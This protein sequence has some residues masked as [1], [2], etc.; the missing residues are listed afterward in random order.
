[1]GCRHSNLL[2]E[3]HRCKNANGYKRDDLSRDQEMHERA[4]AA[5]S[6]YESYIERL[7]EDQENI[8]VSEC[9]YRPD[10]LR[11]ALEST[12]SSVECP[13]CFEKYSSNHVPC[14]LPCGHSF[15][16]EHA[17]HVRKCPICREPCPPINE[18]SKSVALI[19]ASNALSKVIS[20]V[21]ESEVS[22][23]KVLSENKRIENCVNCFDEL[24]TT[25]ETMDQKYPQHSEK[26]VSLLKLSRERNK[27]LL[28]RKIISP[29]NSDVPDTA[30]VTT[31]EESNEPEKKY[32]LSPQHSINRRVMDFCTE[33]HTEGNN[34]IEYDDI[35]LDKFF[36]TLSFTRNLGE[37][38]FDLD[39]ISMKSTDGMSERVEI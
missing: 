11:K 38:I 27:L 37:T 17:P 28:N 26:E 16:L 7:G 21:V 12:I 10:E 33:N 5:F 22:R 24:T 4:L 36:D 23:L 14:T 15:C 30:S 29:R 13:I 8:R 9:G 39:D 18:L 35:V 32:C 6:L 1:M 2:L 19:E 31:D 20:T 3:H 25:T 34:Q